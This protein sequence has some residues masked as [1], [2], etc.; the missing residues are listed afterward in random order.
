MGRRYGLMFKHDK[1]YIIA[2]TGVKHTDISI[3]FFN[4]EQTASNNMIYWLCMNAYRG[5]EIRL[6]ASNCNITIT[7]RNMLLI[8]AKYLKLKSI[9]LYKNKLY[10]STKLKQL[11]DENKLVCN[12]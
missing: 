6:S 8:R 10:T 7:E 12:D 5:D 2:Y 11:I 9:V 1:K 4:D 3:E